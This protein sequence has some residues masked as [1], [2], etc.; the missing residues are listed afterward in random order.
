MPAPMGPAPPTAGSEGGSASTTPPE[1]A[2]SATAAASCSSGGDDK[3]SLGVLYDLWSRL[4][5][6]DIVLSQSGAVKFPKLARFLVN[7]LS[8]K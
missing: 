3:C 2:P 5:H 6:D 4:M 8:G 7:I 1:S